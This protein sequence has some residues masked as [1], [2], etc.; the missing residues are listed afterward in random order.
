MQ[1]IKHSYSCLLVLRMFL[2]MRVRVYFDF[3]ITE[4]NNRPG[5]RNAASRLGLLNSVYAV[6]KK[7]REKLK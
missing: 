4:S 7:Y 1:C 2:F 6:Q 3:A 5:R